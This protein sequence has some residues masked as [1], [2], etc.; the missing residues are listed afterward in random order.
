ME[1]IVLYIYIT[2]PLLII[3]FSIQSLT[4]AIKNKN[5]G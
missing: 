4:K 3:A 1:S 5:N 2:L